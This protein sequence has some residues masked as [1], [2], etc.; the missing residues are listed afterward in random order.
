MRK[1]N[2]LWFAMMAVA[3]PLQLSNTF[4]A[5]NIGKDME[6]YGFLVLAG[7]AL[8]GMAIYGWDAVE[9]FRIWREEKAEES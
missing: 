5:F 9:D 3:F 6:A 1:A 8:V 2:L 4:S 7:L